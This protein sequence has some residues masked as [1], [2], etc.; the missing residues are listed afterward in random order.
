MK[1]A[2][3][4]KKVKNPYSEKFGTPEK[5]RYLGTAGATPEEDIGKKQKT[6]VAA[7]PAASEGPAD[8]EDSQETLVLGAER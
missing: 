1:D 3:S 7:S 5:K 6:D 4:I 8:D 2:T